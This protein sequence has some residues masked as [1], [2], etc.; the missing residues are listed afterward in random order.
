MIRMRPFKAIEDEKATDIHIV[1]THLAAFLAS[2]H[3]DDHDLSKPQTHVLRCISQ[4]P[5]NS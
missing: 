2:P 1:P 4:C 5:W 3:V